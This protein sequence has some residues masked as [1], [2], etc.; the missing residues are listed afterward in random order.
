MTNPGKGTA[1]LLP[2]AILLGLGIGTLFPSL[3][4]PLG[5]LID[6]L[7]L[8]LLAVLFFEVQFHPLVQATRH[9]RFLSLAWV[10]N[11]I[12]VPV[13]GWGIA[14]VFFGNQPALFA[15]LLLYFLF[16]C[17]DWFLG[18]TRMAKGD[19]ALGSILLPINLISQLLLFPVYLALFIGPRAGTDL[20][21]LWGTL[22]KWFLLPFVGAVG[23]RFLL[24]RL[25]PP[26]RF[27]PLPRFAG[28]LIPWILGALVFC[29]FAHNAPTLTAHPGT[30]A[31]ILVAVFLF[32]VLTSLL[33][34][35]LSRRFRL[36]HPKH[37]LLA[38]TTAARNAP[39]ILGLTTIAMPDQPLVYAALIIGIL[40]EIPHLTVLSHLLLRKQDKSPS[41][42]PNSITAA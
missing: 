5:P 28:S 35:M 34:H 31:L 25:L 33:S 26:A 42:S 2:L 12:F 11:F 9:L 21:V 20:A 17:T 1:P 15:G 37:V 19:V 10:A 7:V 22:A 39:L 3:G 16:P 29:I 36:D 32:F 14:T 18:F 24:S 13:I 40:V 27:D 8:T 41:Q 4:A 23:L 38:M 6:P 30:F